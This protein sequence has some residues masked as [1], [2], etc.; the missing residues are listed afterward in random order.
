M[1]EISLASPSLDGAPA[2]TGGPKPR[3]EEDPAKARDAAQQFEA[4]LLGQLL[5]SVRESG[6]GWLGSGGDAAGDCATELAEQQF[7]RLLSQQG[8]LGLAALIEKGLEKPGPAPTPG[9]LQVAK[10]G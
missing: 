2:G 10:S 9:A 3:D 5:R 1:T 7:A 6:G 8:G 4:L